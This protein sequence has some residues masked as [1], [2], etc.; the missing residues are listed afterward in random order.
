MVRRLSERQ[1][2]L[3]FIAVLALSI[4][5]LWSYAQAIQPAPVQP[6]AVSVDLIIRT[7]T[8]RI[9][10]RSNGT[11][12]NTAFAVLQ[13]A[14]ARLGFSLRYVRYTLPPG[15]FVTSINGTA[16][17]EDGR[18]WQYWV[19]SVYGSVAADHMEIRSGDTVVWDFAIPQ[20]GTA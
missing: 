2:A 9:D 6:Q 1:K 8:W 4:A 10:Y 12:N 20:E 13:E 3:L 16:N 15:V 7:P 18:F 14:S 5:G 19:S 17:G 11:D